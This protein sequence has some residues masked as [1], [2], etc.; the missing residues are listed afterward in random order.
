[1]SLYGKGGISNPKACG[2]SRLAFK[3]FIND[4]SPSYDT[5]CSGVGRTLCC[6]FNTS[7]NIFR[8]WPIAKE[9]KTKAKCSSA[10]LGIVTC[11]RKK[12]ADRSKQTNAIV[13]VTIEENDVFLWAFMRSNGWL[14]KNLLIYN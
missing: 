14:D 8:V 1:M 11:F 4:R 9:K 5:T 12:F 6:F 3:R 10:G 7:Y 2:P 13:N